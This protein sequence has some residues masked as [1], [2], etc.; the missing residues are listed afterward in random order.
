LKL[1]TGASAHSVHVKVYGIYPDIC[2]W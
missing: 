1:Q 2:R